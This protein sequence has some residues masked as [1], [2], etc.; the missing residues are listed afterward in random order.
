MFFSGIADEAGLP[1][2]KQIEAHKALGWTHIEMRNI[3]EGNFA[4]VPDEAFEAACA[5]L[6]A[7]GIKVSSFGS[8]IGNWARPIAGDFKKDLEDLQRAV[9]RMQQCGCPV[10]RIMSWTNPDGEVPEE[11]WGNEALR[12]LKELTKIA[13]DG[14]VILGHENCS[15]F[16]GK[17]P[18][19]MQRLKEEI[20]S[21]AL[22]IIYD[23][24]NPVGHGGDTWGWYEACKPA[25]VYVHIKDGKRTGN[26]DAEYTYPG[27]GEGMVREVMADLIKSGYDG[28]FSIE[29]HMAAQVHLGTTAEGEAAFEIYVEYGRRLMKIVEEITGKQQGAGG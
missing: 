4:E 22:G 23:T 7:A 3:P 28:G 27:E 25:T 1:V 29:P 14:G 10:I 13:E 2:E 11:D 24:G 21:D 8:G 20:P 5:K 19:N 18:E 9:P 6:G 15:G 26:G 16:F 17:S 12:R